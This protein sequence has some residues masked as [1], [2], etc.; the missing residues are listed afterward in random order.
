[1]KDFIIAGEC[2]VELCRDRR[3]QIQQGYAGDVYSVAVYLKRADPEARV[4]L[5]CAVGTD[6][7]SNG[8]LES[9]SAE[10]VDTSLMP[11]H[12]LR[13]TGLYTIENSE[14]GER[15]FTYWRS[16]SAARQT[17]DLLAPELEM[18]ADSAPDYFYLSGISLAVAEAETGGKIW[19]LMET[20]R[21]AG[22]QI[23]FDTN[24]RPTLWPDQDTARL[25]FTRA[26]ALSDLVLPGV[27]DMGLLYGIE[28]ADGISR[29]M[30]G[31]GVPQVVVKDGAADILFGSPGS[32]ASHPITPV[33]QV[34]DTTAAGDSFAGTLLGS[35]SR[36]HSL[37]QAIPLA[38]AMAARV[39][40][41]RGA[42][43]PRS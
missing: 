43:L 19:S 7:F 35:L 23:I 30:E 16:E 11:R 26:L 39:I 22:C 2:L 33:R 21:T 6:P 40:Q 1:M 3:G 9:L 42:I 20:L 24:Y 15:R 10:G 38:A 25:A 27:E 34:I 28:D 17:L 14:D 36:G 13:P 18:L 37:E 8:L 12:P 5:M 31:L 32:L 4:R 41:H 29:C